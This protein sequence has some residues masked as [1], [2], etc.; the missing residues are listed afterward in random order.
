MII[1]LDL[2]QFTTESL[3]EIGY[4]LAKGGPEMKT[5]QLRHRTFE[6]LEIV[7]DILSG[8]GSDVSELREMADYWLRRN[9]R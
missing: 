5:R 2:L 4:A 7:I 3:K 9:P 1:D 8:R 6:Q